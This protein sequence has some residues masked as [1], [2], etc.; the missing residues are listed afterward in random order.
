MYYDIFLNHKHPELRQS[1]ADIPE[2]LI[3]QQRGSYISLV[4]SALCESNTSHQSEQGRSSH[5]DSAVRS[6]VVKV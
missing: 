5:S 2:E 6:C 3:L 4:L 1:A